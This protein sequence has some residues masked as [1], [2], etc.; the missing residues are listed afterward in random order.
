MRVDF[1]TIFRVTCWGCGTDP[2]TLWREKARASQI[3]GGNRVRRSQAREPA[4]RLSMLLDNCVTPLVGECPQTCQRFRVG[5]RTLVEPHLR[6]DDPGANRWFLFSTP[7][8]ML[9]PGGSFC[10]WLTLRFAPGLPPGWLVEPSGALPHATGLP[11]LATPVQS[12]I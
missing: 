12:I 11:A 5:Q 9:P 4:Q 3:G 2:S 6:G 1:Q 7:I 10:G 8:Q